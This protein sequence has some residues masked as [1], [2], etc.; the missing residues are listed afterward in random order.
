MVRA[1]LEGGPTP[2][3]AAPSRR[4]LPAHRDYAGTVRTS[5]SP[6]SGSRGCRGDS[7]QLRVIAANPFQF[8]WVHFASS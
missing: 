3:A 6:S 8:L 4:R 1:T 7:R 2:Q 5:S